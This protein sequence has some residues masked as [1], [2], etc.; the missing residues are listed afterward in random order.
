MFIL[1]SGAM[2]AALPG[3]A[4]DCFGGALMALF[5]DPKYQSILKDL[6]YIANLLTIVDSR[7]P[8][9]NEA[10]LTAIITEALPHP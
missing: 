5:R 1:R 4:S 8:G 9:S 2:S 3:T 6:S 7:S 10:M